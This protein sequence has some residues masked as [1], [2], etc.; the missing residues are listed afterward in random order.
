MKTQWPTQGTSPPPRRPRPAGF[1]L[2]GL[3]VSIV[4]FSILATSAYKFF[5]SNERART[6][7]LTESNLSR[8]AEALKAD[9]ERSLRHL[10]HNP[11]LIPY[12]TNPSENNKRVGLIVA[13]PHLFMFQSDDNDRYFPET[14]FDRAGVSLSGA[15]QASEKYG[16]WVAQNSANLATVTS[17]TFTPP[18]SAALDLSQA[19]DS[20]A[21]PMPPCLPLGSAH[22]NVRYRLVKF[23]KDDSHIN[24]TGDHLWTDSN[25]PTTATTVATVLADNVVCFAVRYRDAEDNV[26]TDAATVSISNPS[27][28][29]DFEKVRSIARLEIGVVLLGK[30]SIEGPPDR[31]SGTNRPTASIHVDVRL[32]NGQ[33][34]L[35]R[36]NPTVTPP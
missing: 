13:A 15:I 29:E 9:L 5:I 27:D 18:Y 8:Q 17:A 1:S 31:V 25:Q 23:Q 22:F 4:I 28:L 16:Y 12:S 20:M 6:S 3:L 26:I 10:G 21:A 35:S 7:I 32:P 19:S 34:D 30:Q 14:A 33:W 24:V 11:H 2:I 36:F